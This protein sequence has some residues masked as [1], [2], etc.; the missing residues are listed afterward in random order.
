MP[1]LART[2]VD[3]N[4]K[5]TVPR[6]VRKLLELNDSD[7]SSGSTRRATYTRKAGR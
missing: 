5:T 3:K 1:V 6:E 4:N 7:S 2:K